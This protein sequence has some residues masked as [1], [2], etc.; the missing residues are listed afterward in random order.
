MRVVVPFEEFELAMQ[1]AKFA[2][3][4]LESPS[5]VVILT[6]VL[7]IVFTVL[8]FSACKFPI[9]LP[10][11]NKAFLVAIIFCCYR[12]IRVTRKELFKG[13]PQDEE[14]MASCQ[15]IIRPITP[16]PESFRR[17]SAQAFYRLLIQNKFEREFGNCNGKQL[18]VPGDVV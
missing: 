13:A 6:V 4:Q 7:V 18:F 3:D 10:I 12:S 16:R 17:N 8:I 2:D 5:N 14:L 9:L 1:E 15:T 11:E